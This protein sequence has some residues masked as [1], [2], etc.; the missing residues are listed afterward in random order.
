[1][2]TIFFF[3]AL[4]CTGITQCSL[5]QRITKVQ[6]KITH[7]LKT[8]NSEAFAAELN[9]KEHCGNCGGCGGK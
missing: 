6:D 8:V 9:P 5:E 4:T 1:M 7:S 2:K 3:V